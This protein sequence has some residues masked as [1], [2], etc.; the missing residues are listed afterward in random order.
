M[1]EHEGGD[2]DDQ[3]Q[4]HP[5]KKRDYRKKKNKK[6]LLKSQKE[7]KSGSRGSKR[8]KNK[9]GDSLDSAL[10]TA[11]EVKETVLKKEKESG[12]IIKG[13]TK[14]AHKNSSDKKRQQKREEE[15]E[16]RY[17][18]RRQRDRK[19][20]MKSLRMMKIDEA[21][22]EEEEPRLLNKAPSLDVS[23][24]PF[25]VGGG[26]SETLSFL[27]KSNVATGSKSKIVIGYDQN[28]LIC[29]LF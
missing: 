24:N 23:N 19:I 25:L 3:G 9:P 12:N 28:W 10:S 1:E 22:E 15:D 5:K 20:D 11:A 14:K 21:D 27:G 18:V 29:A 16:E 26:G 4:K 8:G 2:D 6:L 13:L 17:A 7:A